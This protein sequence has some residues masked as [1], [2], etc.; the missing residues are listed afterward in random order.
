M[1]VCRKCNGEGRE[2]YEEDG[3]DVVDACYHCGTTGTV[4]EETDFRDRLHN[5][6]GT[7]AYH[8][9]CEYRDAANND[10]DGDGYDLGGYENGLQPWD[11]FRCRVWDR[12]AEIGEKLAALPINDQQLLVAW[13]EYE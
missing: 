13:S 11:Y 1:A 6:A 5:V 12:T 3:R 7:I 8:L 9:E 4:D 2:R 10:P